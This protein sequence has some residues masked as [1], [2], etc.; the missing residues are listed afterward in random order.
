MVAFRAIIPLANTIRVRV[1]WVLENLETVETLE[2]QKHQIRKWYFICNLKN[3]IHH[4]RLGSGSY[5]SLN[6]TITTTAIRLWNNLYQCNSL[7]LLKCLIN[8]ETLTMYFL[9]LKRKY[10]LLLKS[11]IPL[12][13]QYWSGIIVNV[14]ESTCAIKEKTKGVY[15]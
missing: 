9:K 3:S 7:L 6:F 12:A 11:S 2:A 10:W 14:S 5:F 4:Q 1:P 8:A 15:I 13:L